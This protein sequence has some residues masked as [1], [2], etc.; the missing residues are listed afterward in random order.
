MFLSF[1]ETIITPEDINAFMASRFVHE[2]K[3]NF[4][5]V[6]QGDQITRKQLLQMRNFIIL[7]TLMLNGQ[8]SG[9]VVNLRM[10]AFRYALERGDRYIM[11]VAHH[12]TIRQG[13]ATL[14]L[15]RELWNFR[16][17][18]RKVFKATSSGVHGRP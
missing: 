16:K 4:D 11:T 3:G 9:V 7:M 18:I 15:T 17:Y 6:K 5:R 13:A 12:K 2:V 10:R 1:S 14:C 8:R